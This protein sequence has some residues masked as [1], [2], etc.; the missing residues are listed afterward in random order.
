M[1]DAIKCINRLKISQAENDLEVLVEDFQFLHL[2]NVILV[3]IAVGKIQ[4]LK[5]FQAEQ[6]LGHDLCGYLVGDYAESFQFRT[7]F[8]DS[9]KALF[10]YASWTDE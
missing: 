8:T 5:I 7:V 1:K 6:D 10:V 9:Q 2:L 4:P 3:E